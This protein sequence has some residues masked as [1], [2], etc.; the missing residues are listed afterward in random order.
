MIRNIHKIY[1]CFLFFLKPIFCMQNDNWADTRCKDSFE[2]CCCTGTISAA[3]GLFAISALT[4]ANTQHGSNFV[5][6]VTG[7][8]PDC[9]CELCASLCSSEYATYAF[10]HFN[11]NRTPTHCIICGL[12]YNCHRIITNDTQKLQIPATKKMF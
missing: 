10:D 7:Y 3:C 2:L 9:L 8:Q 11:H 12:L 1:L 4:L 5:L 6:Q